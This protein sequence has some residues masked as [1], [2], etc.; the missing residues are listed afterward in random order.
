MF[1]VT[2][3][4]PANQPPPFLNK[5]VAHSPNFI[6]TRKYQERHLSALLFCFALSNEK[7]PL[8]DWLKKA[9]GAGKQSAVPRL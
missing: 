6:F 2:N 1:F 3:A 8:I 4:E 7:V 5:V 9:H